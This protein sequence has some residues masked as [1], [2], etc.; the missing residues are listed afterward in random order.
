MF[1]FTDGLHLP[2]SH[3][4]NSLPLL[5]TKIRPDAQ[6]CRWSSLAIQSHLELLVITTYKNK[7]RCSISQMVFGRHPVTS[8]IICHCCPCG[9]YASQPSH[10]HIWWIAQWRILWGTCCTPS[11]HPVFINL[12]Q[13]YCHNDSKYVICIS[14]KALYS[15]IIVHLISQWYDMGPCYT[16]DQHR[17][18][19]Q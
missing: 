5:P 2:S 19:Q 17:W 6:F 13:R 3:I 7:A 8:G 14:V 12:S 11:T 16:M 1:N 4:W 18:E 9:A 15:F 10:W